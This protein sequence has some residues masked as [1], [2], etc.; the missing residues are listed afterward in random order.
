MKNYSKQNRLL[1]NLQRCNSRNGKAIPK[2]SSLNSYPNPGKFAPHTR[3]EKRKNKN[4]KHT[5]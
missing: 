1:P 5:Q 4:E 2:E 3:T